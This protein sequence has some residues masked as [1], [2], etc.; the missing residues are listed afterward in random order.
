MAFSYSPIVVV[1]VP[2]SGSTML[3]CLLNAHPDVFV[4]AESIALGCLLQP[5]AGASTQ[6][7]EAILQEEHEETG[8][9][10]ADVATALQYFFWAFFFSDIEAT[11]K[12]RI[13]H[14]THSDSR[15]FRC[16]S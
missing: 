5:L 11:F 1:A 3:R 15:P 4:A 8:R 12:E 2:R 14:D 10:L 13:H 16:R 9:T 6:R 7:L